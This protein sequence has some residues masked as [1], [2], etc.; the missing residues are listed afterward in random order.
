MAEKDSRHWIGP[1][2]T[3]LQKMGF[4]GPSHSKGVRKRV[5]WAV[6]IRQ[7]QTAAGLGLPN[8]I[9]DGDCDVEDLRRE[10][11]THAF[12]NTLAASNIDVFVDFN[13]GM[14]SISTL[15]GDVMNARY[16][17]SQ[18]V[19]EAENRDLYEKL[20]RQRAKCLGT[21]PISAAYDTACRNF[22]VNI[23]LIAYHNSRI[24]LFHSYQ[25][26]L[27]NEEGG[28][29]CSSEVVDA[30]TAICRIVEDMLSSK[31]ICHCHIDVI[32]NIVNTHCNQP[33][34]LRHWTCER[35]TL[36]V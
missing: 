13:I 25:P 26:E 33:R 31:D 14:T 30:S 28:N 27:R 5:W 3:V 19:N 15:L 36:A 4:Y 1:A 9:R 18:R 12:T 16:P 8:R 10:D 2:I 32:T 34:G 24:L 17:T 29:L 6:Y 23:L 21:M 20:L 35:R 22:H 7:R 11:S